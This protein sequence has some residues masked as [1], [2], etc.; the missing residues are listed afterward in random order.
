MRPTIIVDANPIISALIGGFSREVFFD[1]NFNFITT[2]FTIKEIKKYIPYI[3]EKA[4][5]SEKF[6]ESFLH[7]LPIKIYSKDEYQKW[8]EK[9]K[10]LIV[11]EKDVDILALALKTNHPIWSNDPHFEGI[12]EISLIKT[13]D[14]V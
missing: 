2:R 12:K 9:A 1:H 3:A 8:I 7:L 4:K 5:I 13:K 6:I 10:S 14:F 11:D